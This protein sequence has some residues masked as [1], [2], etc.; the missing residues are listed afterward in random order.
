MT[1]TEKREW[2][3]RYQATKEKRLELEEQSLKVE[4]R[5]FLCEKRMEQCGTEKGRLRLTRSINCCNRRMRQFDMQWQKIEDVKLEVVGAIG[6]L[7]S[8]ELRKIM[9]E[10]YIEGKMWKN[11]AQKYNYSL[12]AIYLKHT[13]ALD[14][15]RL[16]GI[17]AA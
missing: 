2:L 16:P 10:R 7:R 1:R 6:S 17:A 13:Q 14:L 3:W 11:I 9:W 4:N 5:L 8:E 15:I 12:S